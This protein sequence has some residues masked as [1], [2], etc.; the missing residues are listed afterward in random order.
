MYGGHDSKTWNGT[1][2]NQI[3]QNNRAVLHRINMYFFYDSITLSKQT[4]TKMYLKSLSFAA[5]TSNLCP[6][7]T[8]WLPNNYSWLSGNLPCSDLRSGFS[9]KYFHLWAKIN[10]ITTQK[11]SLEVFQKQIQP[12]LNPACWWCYCRFPVFLC[13]KVILKVQM[14]LIFLKI[15]FAWYTAQDNSHSYSWP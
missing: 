12:A 6:Y 8:K 14:L 9:W 11:E 4:F 10:F 2:W 7:L 3:L 15:L 1:S 13:R 5:L